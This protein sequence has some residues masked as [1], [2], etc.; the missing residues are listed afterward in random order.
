MALAAVLLA[1]CSE[2][3]TTGPV[4]AGATQAPNGTSIVCVPSAPA[5]G[6]GRSDVVTGFL[7]AMCAGG[8]FSVAKQYLT[9][10]FG[11]RW[12]PRSRVL[13]QE[14]QSTVASSSGS[15]VSLTVPI[16]AQVGGDGVYS[17]SSDPATLDFHLS[18]VGGEWRIDRAQNGIVLTP[19]LFQKFYRPL[20]LQFF[21]QTWTRLVPDLRWFPVASSSAASVPSTRSIV[22]GLIAGPAGPVGGGVT[23]NALKGATVEGISPPS[24]DVT[25]VTLSVPE[26]DPSAELTTRMQQ[27]LIQSLKLPTP[28][29][30]RLVLNDRVA[31]AVSA[32]VSLAPAQVAYV[33]SGG[34][35]GALSASGMFTEDGT[36]GKR[37]VAEHPQAVTVSIRQGLAAVQTISRQVAIVTAASTRVV[38]TRPGVIAPTMDQRSWV[39][40]VPADSPSQM[41]AAN[42][43]GR[44]A[45]FFADLP[46]S[47][48]TS[49]EVSPDGT[50]MLVLVATTNSGPEAFVAG[51]LRNPDG[52]PTGLTTS[53]Y[54]VDMGGNTGR[55][56]GATWVDDNTVAVLVAAP[57]YSTDRVQLQQLGGTASALGETVNA[58]SIVGTSSQSDLRI[59]VQS[60]GL[61]VSDQQLWQEEG[62]TAPKVS[63]L[64]VQR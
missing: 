62:A 30:L 41:Q 35:F 53:R 28:G 45:P 25:T 61:L 58:T 52:S 40:S 3:P 44:I 6:A 10:D 55:G 18:Q 57:D 8:D 29:S 49:I 13:V 27:Q 43:K 31:P 23:A 32:L 38:D 59:R 39:Y 24:A 47:S 54:P 15:S 14:A 5:A 19:T 60:G 46:G 7:A 12:R 34:R 21:D 11:Q 48:V 50:R 51:I 9:P 1:G 16:T 20:P 36:L 2:I 64:A 26:S 33:V 56:I 37:I 42:S 17:P 22:D 4:Q 63:V